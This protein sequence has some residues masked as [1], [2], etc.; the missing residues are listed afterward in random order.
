MYVEITV[1]IPCLIIGSC[2]WICILIFITMAP[3]QLYNSDAEP[4]YFFEGDD[5]DIGHTQSSDSSATN[6]VNWGVPI[7]RVEEL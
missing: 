5:S 1:L 7:A 2:I 3:Q 6:R 4:G